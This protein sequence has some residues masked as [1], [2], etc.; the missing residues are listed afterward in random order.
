[1]FKNLLDAVTATPQTERALGRADQVKNNAGGYVFA[2]D[3]W[4]RLDR[5]LILGSDAPTYY[6]SA[7]SLTVDNAGVVLECAA[8]DGPRTV[9]TIV[10]VSRDGRAP[11]NDAAI[12]ALALTAKRATAV[13]T[14]RAALAAMPKVCRTGTHLFKFVSAVRALGGFGRGTRRALAR[15]YTSRAPESLAYQ[16][17]KYRQREGWSHRDVLR[18]AKPSGYWPASHESA[19][20]ATSAHG[21]L[22]TYATKGTLADG[23]H[24]ALPRAVEV[25]KA[26]PLTGVS[27][28]LPWEALP[29][30]SLKDP[31]TWRGLLDAGGLPLG[32]MLR[33][34]G[35][36]TANGALQPLGDYTAKVCAA[37]TD[38]EALK[39]ARLHPLAIL[40]AL[41]VYRRGSGVRGSLT[42]RP[43]QQIE[44]AL[45]RAFYLAFD[46]IPSTDKRWLLALDV[47]GSMAGGEIAGMTGVTPRVGSAAM[48]LATAK[49]EPRHHFVAFSEGPGRWHGPAKITPLNIHSGMSLA[50]AVHEVS[51][52][53]FGATDCAQ[54]ILWA[55]ENRVV[56]DVFVIYTDNET[57]HGRIHPFEALKRYRREVNPGAKLIVVGMTATGFTI[58]DPTDAGMLDM[59]GFDTAAPGIMAEFASA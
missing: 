11:R 37:L 24:M 12:F 51:G 49:R 53:P 54:P 47:S 30:E 44:A 33:N 21:D 7:R 41:N 32:A 55:L 22:F 56:T 8:A 16:L 18:M 43:I 50:D 4:Q 13:D 39:R 14:R 23:P 10:G 40:V 58:A 27:A 48:A 19:V 20:E 2:L 15:W 31:K 9:D 34:L 38:P 29:S 57:C 36:M 26:S 25:A 3:C 46:S 28:G 52:L 45:D 42:W 5:F 17:V 6:A 35:R 59:V 1:M